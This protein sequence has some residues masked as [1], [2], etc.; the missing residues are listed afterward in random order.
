M[1]EKDKQT[2]AKRKATG[3]KETIADGR[4]NTKLKETK[5]V[6]RATHAN[7]NTMNINK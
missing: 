1:R 3:K 6:R 4:R 7:N 5:D 2:I